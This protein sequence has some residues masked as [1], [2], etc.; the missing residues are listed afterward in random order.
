MIVLGIAA[1]GP[2]EAADVNVGDLILAVDGKPVTSAEDLLDALSE[3]GVGQT[4]V[5]HT[6]RGGT[7]KEARVVVGE[8][9]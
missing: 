7:A 9:E 3:H 4:V 8:R 2:A 6:L 1:S 5:L